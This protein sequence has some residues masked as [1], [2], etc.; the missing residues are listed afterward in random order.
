MLV[1]FCVTLLLLVGPAWELF[2]CIYDILT[3]TYLSGENWL[4]NLIFVL[5]SFIYGSVHCVFYLLLLLSFC[6]NPSGIGTL[7]LLLLLLSLLLLDFACYLLSSVCSSK[8]YTLSA[9][10]LYNNAMLFLFA[11]LSVGLTKRK[12]PN[13]TKDVYSYT[14]QRVL[15][16]LI[17]LL[18]SLLVVSVM[19]LLTYCDTDRAWMTSLI[20]ASLCSVFRNE[21]PYVPRRGGGSTDPSFL[22][23]GSEST[24][25]CLWLHAIN[26]PTLRVW[27]EKSSS[28]SL[29]CRCCSE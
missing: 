5:A 27:S 20:I 21:R 7:H 26:G 2:D 29:F 19:R 4:A 13:L 14:K 24:R 3:L 1:V 8:L 11:S 9:S 25:L 18:L 22:F 16:L 12:Y 17:L 28:T 15:L 23:A 10:S 6:G